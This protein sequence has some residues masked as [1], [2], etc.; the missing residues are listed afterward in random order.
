[1]K[2]LSIVIPVY[3]KQP[4]S[5]ELLSL[6]QLAKVCPTKYDICYIYPESWENETIEAYEDI[7]LK[8]NVYITC[9]NDEYFRSTIDYSRLLKEQDFYNRFNDY[10]YILIYQT[11]CWAINFSSLDEWLL[12][13]FDYIGAPIIANKQHWPSMPCCGN[14]G[15]SLRKVSSFIKYTSDEALRKQLDKNEIYNR[16]EDV[17]FCE[18]VS[19]YLYIDMPSWEEC[20]EFAWDMNPDVLDTVHKF[21]WQN[22][23]GCHAWTKN[24]PYWHDK[25]DI[26]KEVQLECYKANKEFIDKWLKDGENVKLFFGAKAKLEWQCGVDDADPNIFNNIIQFR[27]SGVRVKPGTYFP[28]LVAIVQ[29]SIIGSRFRYMT[30][31]ECARIQGFPE[32]FIINKSDGKAYK[33]FGNSVNVDVVKLFAEFLLDIGNTRQRYTSNVLF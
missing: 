21:D 6:K 32:N 1:M 17:Y 24:I 5:W 14:G 29:K 27:P 12:Q 10:E 28:A 18:G 7:F 33:Q 23:I 25:L 22:I 30:P 15:L 16:Y 8:H 4:K 3:N 26:P 2:Q 9:F 31:R 20:A 11:D 19:Q 13:G